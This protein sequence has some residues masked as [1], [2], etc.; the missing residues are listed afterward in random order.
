MILHNGR[1]Q[2]LLSEAAAPAQTGGRASMSAD[3][4]C[5]PGLN[6]LI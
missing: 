2:P 5:F 4:A 1:A 6:N 3:I